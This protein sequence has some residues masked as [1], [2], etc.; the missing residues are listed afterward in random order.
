MANSKYGKIIA[1]ITTVCVIL[2]GVAFIVCAAHIYF[3]NGSQ[4]YSRE[5]VNKYLGVLLVPSIITLVLA[6]GG[7]IYNSI[8]GESVEKNTART[9]IELLESFASRYD[10]ASF[11]EKTQSVIK[12][13]KKRRDTFTAIAFSFSALIFVLILVYLFTAKFTVEELNADV[14][15]A[16]RVVLPLAAIALG[17]H[18]PR[19]YVNESSAKTQLDAMKAS[20]KENGAPKAGT[21]AKKTSKN[22]V[23][24]ARYVI[25]GVSVLLVVLGIFN[26][27]VADVLSKAVKICTECIGLG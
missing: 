13:E 26:G 14:I 20:I 12:A 25:L 2:L 24:I 21:A 7:V 6:M 9:Q 15:S 5:I 18:V 22:P 16:L 4:P 11:D 10:I 8:T 27:G 3:N 17:I 19:L 23:L 1:T